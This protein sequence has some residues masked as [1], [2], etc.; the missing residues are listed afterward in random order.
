MSNKIYQLITINE[1]STLNF[2]GI[3]NS[4]HVSIDCVEN[5]RSHSLA[6][7]IS[8][9]TIIYSASYSFYYNLLGNLTMSS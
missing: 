7:I 8:H 9:V 2:F 3:K 6:P 5:A 4:L 1:K